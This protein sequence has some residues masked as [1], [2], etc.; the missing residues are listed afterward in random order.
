M[1]PGTQ[2]QQVTGADLDLSQVSNAVSMNMV[3]DPRKRNEM[4]RMGLSDPNAFALQNQGQLQQAQQPSEFAGAGRQLASNQNPDVSAA[5]LVGGI[6]NVDGQYYYYGDKDTSTAQFGTGGYTL[7]DI[8]GGKQNILNP[9]GSVVGVNYMDPNSALG[10]LLYDSAVNDLQTNVGKSLGNM[11]PS[12]TTYSSKALLD[13]AVYG[14]DG[15]YLS[16]G[17]P[18]QY[19]TLE[20]LQ[21]ALKTLY[22][23]PVTVYDNKGNLVPAQEGDVDI[24][25]LDRLAQFLGNQKMEFSGLGSLT[26]P[27][28]FMDDSGLSRSFGTSDPTISGLDTLYG[29]TPLIWDNQLLGYTMDLTPVEEGDPYYYNGNTLALIDDNGKTTSQAYLQQIYNNPEQWGELGAFLPNG[30]YFVSPENAAK[31]P[32]ITYRKEFNMQEIPSD[33]FFGEAFDVL[34]PILDTIDPLQHDATQNFVMD[35]LGKDSQKETFETVA[36]IVASFFGPW[37]AALNF[38]NSASKGDDAGAIMNMLSMVGSAP[39]GEAGGVTTSGVTDGAGWYAGGGA[40]AAAGA[41]STASG[42]SSVGSAATAGDAATTSSNVTYN[43]Q[44]TNYVS[45]KLGVTPEVAKGLITASKNTLAGLFAGQDLNS[46]L[47]AGAFSGMG[48]AAGDWLSSNYSGE[49]GKIGSRALGG[50]ASGA[51]NSLFTKNDVLR[52]SLY[53]AMSGGLHGW[54]NSMGSQ[55]GQQV[56]PQASATNKGLAQTFS[57]L[58]QQMAETNGKR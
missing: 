23:S 44:L 45:D 40:D 27:F 11:M 52:G 21:S 47:R 22:Q 19:N 1:T 53:G 39:A 12:T 14:D 25:A 58:V 54:F 10:S 48:G 34:D 28:G 8:G 51:I 38:A 6:H 24:Y 33:S 56:A 57:Q 37:G 13:P 17:T 50:A 31:L 26:N 55:P 32:G 49:L 35:L 18:T 2:Q 46:A 30:N 29:S 7:S 9:D 20:E 15:T 43:Q 41:G 3:S 36:P 5:N 42:A 4:I 16:G